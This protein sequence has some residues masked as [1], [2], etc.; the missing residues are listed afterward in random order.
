MKK[1]IAILGSTGSIGKSTLKVIDKNR[2]SFD[3]CFLSANNNYKELVKQAIK[4]KSKN[5]LIK[6]K[7]FYQRTK[8]L[9][10]NNKT[11]VYTGDI[12]IN[13][14]IS[15]KLDYTMSAIV[16]LA[17][18]QPTIDSVKISKNLAI[19]NKE[20]IICGWEIISKLKRKFNT[21]ILPVDSEHFSINELTKNK[22]NNQI[23]EIIITAS[24]GPFLNAFK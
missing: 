9:L 17:G 5:I 24:G 16:G 8:K 6:N 1:K 11:K 7:K 15:F 12:S 18:L 4:Y 14:I 20:T 3:I 22:S 2:K 21:N 13:K 19:A 10:K 23:E